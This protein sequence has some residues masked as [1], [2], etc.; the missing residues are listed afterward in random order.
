MFPRLG[1]AAVAAAEGVSLRLLNEL[2]RLVR[3]LSLEAA[4]KGASQMWKAG[5]V[6]GAAVGS[7]AGAGVG[8]A[9]GVASAA[10]AAGAAAA[11]A[12]GASQNQKARA[13]RSL[14]KQQLFP[15]Q[16]RQ[17]GLLPTWQGQAELL[18]VQARLLARLAKAVARGVSS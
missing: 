11:A 12:G 15:S 4:A 3:L 18:R 10:V 14:C 2:P 13:A 16:N 9:A 1:T 5:D 8:G 7:A 17:S 6:A